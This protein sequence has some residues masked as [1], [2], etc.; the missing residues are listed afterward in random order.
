MTFFLKIVGL[1]SRDC[2]LIIK[3]L[4]KNHLAYAMFAMDSSMSSFNIT[5]SCYIITAWL[6]LS[7]RTNERHVK[8][9]FVHI[10]VLK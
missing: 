7:V 2:W 6:Y 10:S 9:I 8:M 5:I 1:I 3:C 4:V